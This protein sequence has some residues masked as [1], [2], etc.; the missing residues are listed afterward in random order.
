MFPSRSRL[1]STFATLLEKPFPPRNVIL[2]SEI[3]ESFL[4]GTG[5][6]GQKIN[7]TSSA[8]QLKHL[9]SGIVVSVNRRVVANKTDILLAG[10]FLS[11]WRR[12]RKAIR[13]ERQSKRSGPGRR[14]RARTR[15]V[16]ASIVC[17]QRRRLLQLKMVWMRRKPRLA[18]NL[19][20]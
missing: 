9:P 7:K 4:K 15:R 1:F 6:G 19:S 13:V 11:V 20:R 14:K 2:E 18:T 3:S 12:L 16:T 5:P 8:V 10:Y 17:W